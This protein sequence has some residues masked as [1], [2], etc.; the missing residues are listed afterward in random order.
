[1]TCEGAS[2][3]KISCVAKRSQKP[4]VEVDRYVV[5]IFMLGSQIL[6]R[7]E[8]TGV[9]TLAHPRRYEDTLASLDM[10]STTPKAFTSR[11]SYQAPR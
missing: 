4:E 10:S 9:E 8:Q 5:L 6:M 11:I 3:S 7:Q 1:M 2:V